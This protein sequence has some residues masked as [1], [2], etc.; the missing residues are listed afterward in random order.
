MAVQI[1]VCILMTLLALAGHVSSQLQCSIP[2]QCVDSDLIQSEIDDDKYACHNECKN[3]EACKWFTFNAKVNFCEL[4]ETCNDITE[5]SCEDC[6]TSQKDCDVYQCGLQGSCQVKPVRNDCFSLT[7]T[8]ILQ[9]HIIK[10]ED[11][12]TEGQCLKDC[13]INMDCQWYTFNE[14]I[15]LCLLFETCPTVDE[16][17]S[18]CTSGE[19]GCSLGRFVKALMISRNTIVFVCRHWYDQ[20]AGDYRISSRKLAD[21]RSHQLK[22]SIFILF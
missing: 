7:W 13:Q 17:C 1:N 21:F 18:T 8:W 10:Q 4:F 12:D 11:V 22:R 9:G 20:I 3:N 15:N 19:N 5:E 2:G 6:V 16:T 14:D